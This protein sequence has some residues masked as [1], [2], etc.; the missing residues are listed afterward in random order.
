MEEYI[1]KAEAKTALEAAFAFHSYAGG[2]AS[3]V[4]D[5]IPA[6]DVV[7]RKKWHSTKKRLPE[8]QGTYLICTN[9]GKVISAPFAAGFHRFNGYAGRS[10]THWMETPEPPREGEDEDEGA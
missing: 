4:I 7:P 10:C 5:K 6:A 3:N 8:K 9:R 1:S 2:M